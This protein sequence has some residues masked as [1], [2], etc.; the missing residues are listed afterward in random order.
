LWGW[1]QIND[2][3]SRGDFGGIRPVGGKKQEQ[4]GGCRVSCPTL[5]I[6]GWGGR[7]RRT[8][9]TGNC[10]RLLTKGVN[11]TWGLRISRKG[12]R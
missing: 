3:V 10:G 12:K 5:V 7:Q 9:G 1:E 11:T 4:Y 6:G 2:F 8:K